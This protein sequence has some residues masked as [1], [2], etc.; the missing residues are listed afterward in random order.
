MSSI[1]KAAPVN[2]Y[3]RSAKSPNSSANGA[4]MTPEVDDT[5]TEGKTPAQRQQDQSEV[6]ETH[7]LKRPPSE[8]SRRLSFTEEKVNRVQEREKH[9]E[10]EERQR[11]EHRKRLH[12]EDP[13]RDNY[14]YLPLN[15][16]QVE[17]RTSISLQSICKP[18]PSYMRAAFSALAPATGAGIPRGATV[19]FC[20][21]VTDFNVTTEAGQSLDNDMHIDGNTPGLLMFG[22]L[23]CGRF[24]TG[25]FGD[26]I[27]VMLSEQTKVVAYERNLCLR[28]IV[29]DDR[30]FEVKLTS[31]PDFWRL[32]RCFEY[33]NVTTTHQAALLEGELVA[34]HDFLRQSM[35]QQLIHPAC[36][37]G[38]HGSAIIACYVILG[39]CAVILWSYFTQY[40]WH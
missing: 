23:P 13:L 16:S 17:L 38:V 18:V 8:G 40:L 20:G 35:D 39:I 34:L 11:K 30:W 5:S 7:W 27:P 19:M 4:P 36:P 12:D 6:P 22:R 24:A 31:I 25:D 9:D 15:M 2:P 29:A 33:N 26:S 21:T 28:W 3:P 10:Q 1:K 37:R 14:G 32:N